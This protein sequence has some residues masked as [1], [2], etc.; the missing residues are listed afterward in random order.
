M[1]VFAVLASSLGFGVPVS[2][3]DFTAGSSVG[4]RL[5]TY[6][7]TGSGAVNSLT[8]LVVFG[9]SFLDSTPTGLIPIP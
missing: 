5:R 6:A 3:V 2:I 9:A 7:L 8:F 4:R 1:F